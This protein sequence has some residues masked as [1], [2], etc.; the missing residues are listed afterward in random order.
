[1][2]PFSFLH[3]R[4]A[5]FSSFL[6]SF[7]FFFSQCSDQ[8]CGSSDTALE[9]SATEE[10]EEEEV[11]G[12]KWWWEEWHASP[13]NFPKWRA[14]PPLLL[15]LL[16]LQ[17]TRKS[18]SL[19][20]F[21]SSW[22][23]DGRSEQRKE[24]EQ[25]EFNNFFFFLRF[26]REVWTWEISAGRKASWVFPLPGIMKP[27]LRFSVSLLVLGALLKVTTLHL[28]YTR[29]FITT[30][31]CCFVAV[32]LMEVACFTRTC[33][34]QVSRRCALLLLETHEDKV[35]AQRKSSVSDRECRGL[36]YKMN[37][38]TVRVLIGFKFMSA[39]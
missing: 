30:R 25:K 22:C 12:E 15:L 26:K 4:A 7:F 11:E 9:F 8:A 33:W 36:L 17:L 5:S 34:R 13:E 18:F 19:S 37:D 39:V 24:R 21:E 35:T 31:W 29:T 14:P 3:D 1:M 16:L 6:F 32:G 23:S 20:D 38:G 10:E 27:L 2:T 28:L